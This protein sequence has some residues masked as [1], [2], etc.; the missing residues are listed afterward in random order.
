MCL[1]AT[2]RIAPAGRPKDSETVSTEGVSSYRRL[3]F[4]VSGR[5]E[6]MG[7]R[8]VRG[9]EKKE[10][11]R[12]GPPSASSAIVHF[13]H[14]RKDPAADGTVDPLPEAGGAGGFRML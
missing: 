6:G 14:S 7:R 10:Q 12:D 8:A 13:G 4:G 1:G 9:E 2:F 11:E 3:R 5:L